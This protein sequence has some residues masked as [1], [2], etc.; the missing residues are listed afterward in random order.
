[1]QFWINNHELIFQRPTKVHE[2]VGR[3]H[4]VAFE[5]FAS[6]YFSIPNCTRKIIWLFI[7]NIQ[8]KVNSLWMHVAQ[9]E[10][11]S[12]ASMCSSVIPTLK[13]Y[14]I[15]PHKLL[16]GCIF[17]PRL[18]SLAVC[19]VLRNIDGYA[20]SHSTPQKCEMVK[21]KKRTRITQSGKITPPRARAILH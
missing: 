10:L 20:F 4:L 9:A 14:F 1:M 16:F 5:K 17:G 18:N 2:P 3:V 13:M 6:A 7:N 15:S 21:Q 8:E 19:P 12:I 11:V